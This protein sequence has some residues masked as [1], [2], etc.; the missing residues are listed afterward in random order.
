[1]DPF[2]AALLVECAWQVPSGSHLDGE[3]SHPVLFAAF[4]T[5]PGLP[6]IVPA[7]TAWCYRKRSAVTA[8]TRTIPQC[9]CAAVPP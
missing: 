7:R 5:V 4:V 2:R 8:V 9:R 3:T 6:D 1:L